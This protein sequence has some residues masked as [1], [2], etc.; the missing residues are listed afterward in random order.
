MWSLERW[1]WK[2]GDD[3]DTDI[4][5]NELQSIILAEYHVFSSS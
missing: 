2:A 3:A 5:A 4:M 1:R